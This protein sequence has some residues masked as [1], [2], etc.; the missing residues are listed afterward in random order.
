MSVRGRIFQR[1]SASFIIIAIEGVYHLRSQRE[2][3]M[4]D[5]VAVAMDVRKSI[6][7]K[8]CAITIMAANTQLP[9][10]IREA[11]DA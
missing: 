9:D 6:M 4:G 1:D 7:Q 3:T 5:R 2:C 8:G 10:D 11:Y